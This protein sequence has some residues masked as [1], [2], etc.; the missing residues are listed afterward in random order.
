M[1]FKTSASRA[2]RAIRHAIERAVLNAPL[3]EWSKVF[4]NAVSAEKG[5]LTNSEF[6]AGVADYIILENENKENVSQN[7]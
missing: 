7:I 4:V 3:E 6:I 2:E 5:K 1:K